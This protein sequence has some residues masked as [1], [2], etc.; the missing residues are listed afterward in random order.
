[1][2]ILNV[3]KNKVIGAAIGIFGMCGVAT[4]GDITEYANNE[5]LRAGFVWGTTEVVGCQPADDDGAGCA[6]S[7][8]SVPADDPPWTFEAGPE[9]TTLT[10]VGSYMPWEQYRV[11][12][13]GVVIGDT[14]TPGDIG[15]FGDPDACLLSDST[16]GFFDL[17]PGLHSITMDVIAYNPDFPSG[18]VFMRIDGDVVGSEIE[19]AI[20]IQ[21]NKSTNKVKPDSSGLIS[22]AILTTEDFDA[23]QVNLD[24]VRFGPDGAAEVHSRNHV[25]DV[26]N[27]GDMDLLLHFRILQTGI[28]CGD[29]EATLT[30]ET[31]DEVPIIGTDSIVTV[32]CAAGC[33]ATVQTVT[34]TQDDSTNGIMNTSIK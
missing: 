33:D 32:R 23:Q 34:S 6:Y 4:A 29:T 2:K 19:V 25:Q 5:W 26:D 3:N 31:W 1:M 16:K 28:Q 27:D 21:P 20:D 17:G 15:C 9:G 18:V 24:T 30:G 22:V 12:D 10:V 7:D 8:L 11:Y 14:S 13:Y